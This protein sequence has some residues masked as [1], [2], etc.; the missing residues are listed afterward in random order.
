VRERV[1]EAPKPA[2]FR[3]FVFSS[4]WSCVPL[5]IVC[6][7]ASSIA[8]LSFAPAQDDLQQIAGAI[9]SG[10]LKEAEAALGS[11][12]KNQPSS[13]D[14]YRLLGAVFERQQKF[15]QAESALQRAAKL[16]A[17][18]DPQVLFLLCQTEF[19]L[20]KKS[21]A[22]HLAHHLASL[23]GDN[24]QAHYALGR[25]L[26][27][28]GVAEE[29]TQELRTAIRLAPGN[30]PVTTE[31]IV[32]YLDQGRSQEA[33]ALLKSFIKSASY[34]DLLDAGSRLG[35]TGKFP[36][37][38]EVL[39]RAVQ[40]K[41][42]S[43]DATFN[44]GFAYYHQGNWNKALDTLN[45]IP[46]QLAE[47]QADY[48]YLRGKIE[49]ALHQEQAAGEEYLAALKLQPDNESLCSDTGLL[50]FH[51]ESFW[52]SLDVYEN[53][54]RHLP[55]SAPIETG[56]AL[57]YFRLGKYDDAAS[58]FKKVLDLRPDADAAREALAFLDYVSGHL[59]EAKQL[60]ES[61]LNSAGADYYL[62]YL[63][64][65][66][67]RRLDPRGDPGGALRS[68]DQSLRLS[69]QFAPAYFQRAK[70]RNDAGETSRAL[71]D[72]DTA[73]R[74]DRTYAEPF[75]LIA[76]IDYR[77][78]KTEQAEQARHEYGLR[79]KEREEKQQK[80]LVENRLLQ[81]LQ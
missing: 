23:A 21:E 81:A 7:L 11:F 58:T 70:L 42:D 16:S 47:N 67:L 59:A 39:E 52:K 9:Q 66:V 27:E 38:V 20:K 56:L 14:A 1:N 46:P 5:T 74:L 48:H 32:A 71:A 49:A 72:L 76:Q 24:P 22:L 18:K 4:G 65:L 51:F 25:L 80:Q 6:L 79:E 17:G 68:L 26:R 50:F 44:L 54:A 73:T 36:A 19:D 8:G 10:K 77:L 2:P 57:T 60:V 64:A 55:D 37:A 78:G 31:L 35:E 13:V 12:L 3:R 15:Q 41:P 45:L 53:C 63:H 34:E 30:P 61:R 62:Y 40:W 43:Y 33:D 75:Y 28:N 69:P 29:A